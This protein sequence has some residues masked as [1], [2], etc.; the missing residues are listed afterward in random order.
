MSRDGHVHEQ[1]RSG[2]ASTAPGEAEVAAADRL[3]LSRQARAGPGGDAKCCITHSTLATTCHPVAAGAS[4]A[5]AAAAAVEQDSNHGSA[6][7]LHEADE[8]RRCCWLPWQSATAPLMLREKWATGAVS[9]SSSEGPRSEPA[10]AS[11]GNS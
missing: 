2:C 4:E 9:R 3:L 8:N 5:A 6:G 1:R 11:L 7:I 10:Q